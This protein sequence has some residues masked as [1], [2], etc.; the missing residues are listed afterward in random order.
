MTEKDTTE[1]DTTDGPGE[2]TEGDESTG[3]SHAESNAEEPTTGDPV[4]EGEVPAGGEESSG[5][6]DARD[7]LLKG[8]LA[9]LAL[10]ALIATVRF[11]LSASTAI[12]VWVA[13]E[14]RAL[15]QAA[16]NLVVLLVSAIG[17]SFVVRELAA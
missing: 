14:Y 11:Y 3:S 2:P 9:L 4:A 7:Y 13:H 8:A 12:D 5:G 6:R 1:N 10:L 17:V 16:F 15:F